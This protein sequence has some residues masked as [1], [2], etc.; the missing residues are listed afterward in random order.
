MLC[1]SRANWCFK[2]VVLAFLSLTGCVTLSS[3][4][5]FN[6]V[7][8][9]VQGRLG[10]QIRWDAGQYDDPLVRS[11]IG[12][13]LS[14]P[15]TAETAVQVALLNNRELQST[16]ADLGISQANV[17]Q[18][19]LWKNPVLN[20]AVTFSLAGE[21]PDYTFDLALR[22]LDILYIP[23]RKRV[24][25]SQLEEAKF[26]VTAQVMNVAGQ[27]YL[28]VIDYLGLTQ[29]V[30]VL[31]GPEKAAKAIVESGKVLRKAGNITDYDYEAE[32]AQ[33]VQ[34]AAEL[35]RTQV[36]AAQARE[37]VNRL[38]GLTGL[39]TQW[40]SADRLPPIAARDPPTADVER[41]AI[42]ASVDLAAARQRLISIGRKY[43]VVDINS[44]L[45]RLD[46]GGRFERTVGEEE[47]GPSFA[48]EIPLFDW[49]QARREAAR[50][51]M[52]KARDE[53]TALAVRI[54]SLA[55]SQ[56]AKLLSAR[57][58]ALYYAD[59]VV[60]QSQR[61]LEAAERQYNVMQLG[62]FQ[63]LQAKERQI[64]ASLEYVTA[65]TTYWRERALLAQIL[66][67]K[68]PDE[69][70]GNRAAVAISTAQ[71]TSSGNQLISSGNQP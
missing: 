31:T 63:L 30:G 9:A 28:A 13:L 22:L 60:P 35:A 17:V 62:V 67:G 26:Q 29:C 11:T 10:K 37:R 18:T 65:L 41:K 24:A 66:N 38:L 39:Q 19:T 59:T 40:R 7:A 21:S 3:E 49:G 61:L 14:R 57:Q 45:P 53:F 27:T 2:A 16:Y 34:I 42:E 47:V 51:E 55:R 5:S 25:E 43:Q 1:P 69:L 33:Q 36:S 23:L 71:A 32:V 46:A 54:R 4:Q 56:Q 70:E 15:L 12:R 68:L 58:T 8:G 44:L 50:M 52:L 20:G 64:R 6:E 48:V